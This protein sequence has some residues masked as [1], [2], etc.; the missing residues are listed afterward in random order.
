MFRRGTVVT[1]SF[2]SFILKDPHGLRQFH[3]DLAIPGFGERPAA[4]VWSA[5]PPTWNTSDK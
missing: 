4:P 1:G 5:E 2:L 3:D